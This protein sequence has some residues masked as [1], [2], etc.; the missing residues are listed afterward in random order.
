MSNGVFGNQLFIPPL[1]TTKAAKWCIGT[2]IRKQ[3]ND[4]VTRKYNM[5]D[6]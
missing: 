2:L 4:C 6:Q 1:K 5:H 3:E